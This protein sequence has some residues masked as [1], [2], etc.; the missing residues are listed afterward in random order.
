MVKNIVYFKP[1][2]F[3]EKAGI[4]FADFARKKPYYNESAFL[5]EKGSSRSPYT[6]KEADFVVGL[7]KKYFK[8]P[9]TFLDIP[10]GVGRHARILSKR[11]FKVVGVDASD[12]LLRIAKAQDRRTAYKKYDMRKFALGDKFDVV[13]S[14][15]DAYTY[16]SRTEDMRAFLRNVRGHLKDGGLLILDSRNF[17][18]KFPKDRLTHKV[19]YAKPY[20]V[21]IIAR[22]NTNLKERVHESFFVYTMINRKNIK[23][24]GVIF[25]Q[26]LV[27]IYSPASIARLFRKKFKIL[28]LFG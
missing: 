19:V 6:R 23:D 27:R 20:D 7:A 10:C 9:K 2:K 4:S 11:G 8:N 28:G 24:H 26:E 12:A 22:R 17:W 18:K 21:E 16:L 13:F 5:F 25:D 14:L 15:W 3:L 1:Y